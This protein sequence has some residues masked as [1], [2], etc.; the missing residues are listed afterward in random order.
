M[1]VR[2]ELKFVK[3]DFGG[4]YVADTGTQEM[5]LL[6]ASNWDTRFQ[7]SRN[8]NQFWRIKN[9]KSNHIW[10]IA[11]VRAYYSSKFGAGTGPVLLNCLDCLG[12]E[13]SLL[14]CDRSCYNEY[15]CSHT[16]DV[17]VRCEHTLVSGENYN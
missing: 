3:M 15:S 11:D 8:Q 14:A 1:K 6:C 17:G 9:Y 2:G 5:P 7:V 10:W 16:S 12:T 4:L 13:T